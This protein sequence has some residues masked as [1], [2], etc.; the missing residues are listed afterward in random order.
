MNKKVVI[1]IFILT[2]IIV[3][4]VFFNQPK[5]KENT[6]APIENNASIMQVATA[7]ASLKNT[8]K[9]IEY[10]K[11]ELD[12]ASDKRRVLFFYASWC[13]K[14]KP[15][16]LDFKNNADKIPND[17]VITRVNYNDP[18]TD[19]EEK[20]LAKKYGITYQHTFVQIDSEGKELTKW[21]GG[22]LE[23]LLSRIK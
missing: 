6:I 2:L 7:P 21:N 13:P 23:E 3:I 17:L 5:I 11:I 8:T 20:E 1:P 19:T 16:D 4:I 9:Y 12:K 15:A 22:Q 10:S 14:C 18:D